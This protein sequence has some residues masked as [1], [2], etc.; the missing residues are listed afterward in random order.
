MPEAARGYRYLA[1]RVTVAS[2]TSRN[3][4]EAVIY[5][6]NILKDFA[7]GSHLRLVLPLG[8]LHHAFHSSL[9]PIPMPLGS[10]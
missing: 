6:E 8:L 4:L 9:S 2:G 7:S 3:D 1:M 5:D 10:P